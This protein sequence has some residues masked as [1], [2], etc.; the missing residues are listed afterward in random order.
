MMEMAALVMRLGGLTAGL[1]KG[2]STI[3]TLIEY[4][5]NSSTI[6]L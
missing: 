3:A 6:A 4:I 2:Y 5:Y 1:D